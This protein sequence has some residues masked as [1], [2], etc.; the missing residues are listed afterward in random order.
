MEASILLCVLL[1]FQYF[2]YLLAILFLAV[3]ESEIVYN[4]VNII[5]RLEPKNLCFTLST[6]GMN[7]IAKMH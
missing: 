6:D 5:T 3:T 2:M 1:H 7:D 4:L